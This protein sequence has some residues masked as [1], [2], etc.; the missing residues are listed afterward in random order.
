MKISLNVKS[1]L[2]YRSSLAPYHTNILVSSDAVSLSEA[3]EHV[4]NWTNW[5][6]GGGDEMGLG[7][8]AGSVGNFLESKLCAYTVQNQYTV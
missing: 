2:N 6:G 8:P 4:T 3:E 5:G 7:Q 1:P